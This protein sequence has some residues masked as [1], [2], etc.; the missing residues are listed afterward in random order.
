MHGSRR[1]LKFIVQ[2]IYAN[3]VYDGERHL[4]L[5]E[6]FCKAFFASVLLFVSLTRVNSWNFTDFIVSKIHVVVTNLKIQPDGIDEWYVVPDRDQD[7]LNY[8]DCC[9]RSMLTRRYWLSSKPS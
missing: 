9:A 8:R 6:V 4:S 2:W 3:A 7:E 5:R 1:T